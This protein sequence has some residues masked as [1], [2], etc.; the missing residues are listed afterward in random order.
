LVV[1][2]RIRPKRVGGRFF[3]SYGRRI[4][5]SAFNF[6]FRRLGQQTRFL[7]LFGKT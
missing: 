6:V 7:L 3:L 5:P 1:R 2:L 4:Q